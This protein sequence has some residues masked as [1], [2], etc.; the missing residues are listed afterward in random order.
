MSQPPRF[1]PIPV[2]HLVGA[3]EP[4]RR[5]RFMEIVRRQMRERRFSARTER[6]YVGWIRRYILFHDRR[7]PRELGEDDVRRFLSHL[8]L[9]RDAASSTQNQALAALTFLYDKVLGTPFGR[10]ESHTGQASCSGAGG[11]VAE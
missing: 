4:E 1:R 6:A 3:P 8:V 7:H 5:L 9:E 10:V 2:A 11:A